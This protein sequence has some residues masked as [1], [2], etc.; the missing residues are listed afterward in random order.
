M[1]ESNEVILTLEKDRAMMVRQAGEG[2]RIVLVGNLD[3]VLSVTQ[4]ERGGDTPV[5]V[6]FLGADEA[7]VIIARDEGKSIVWDEDGDGIPE[8]KMDKTGS[9]RLKK[10]EW[11]KIEKN[12]KGREDVSRPL[13]SRRKGKEGGNRG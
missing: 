6:E 2:G 10:I 4:L 12:D 7:K 11:E 13:R 5:L 8:M 3:G 9:Y 1:A